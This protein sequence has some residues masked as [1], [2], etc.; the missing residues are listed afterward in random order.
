MNLN[1]GDINQDRKLIVGKIGK[2]Q[3]SEKFFWDT[4]KLRVLDLVLFGKQSLKSIA[5][6]PEVFESTATVAKWMNSTEFKVQYDRIIEAA[7][8]RRKA[9]EIVVYEDMLD[10]LHEVFEANYKTLDPNKVM[11][12][13]RKILKEKTES[14]GGGTQTI[15]AKDSNLNIVSPIAAKLMEEAV[16]KGRG[17]K[18]LK[19]SPDEKKDLQI[20]DDE[21]T[22]TGTDTDTPTG[23]DGGR[24][25]EV[26]DSKLD[27]SDRSEDGKTDTI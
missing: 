8:Q 20:D 5:E 10:K 21:E 18:K 13:L 1:E 3:H 24:D 23:S 11:E 7:L 26:I 9:K 25:I 2:L 14:V 22:T 15:I 27:G 17:Y 4:K 16:L 12:E 19:I 6:D